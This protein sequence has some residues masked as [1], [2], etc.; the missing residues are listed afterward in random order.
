MINIVKELKINILNSVK[1]IMRVYK[2]GTM[3]AFTLS[4]CIV[5]ALSMHYFGNFDGFRFVLLE[6]ST[7]ICLTCVFLYIVDFIKF[8]IKSIKRPKKV[9]TYSNAIRV[10]VGIPK[11]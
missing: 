3:F 6:L 11:K 1:F 10:T 9:K 2:R 8:I 4:I 5:L 7:A